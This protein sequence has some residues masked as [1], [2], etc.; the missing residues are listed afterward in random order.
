MRPRTHVRLPLVRTILALAG[1]L[2]AVPTLPAQDMEGQKIS[3]RASFDPA[4]ARPGDKVT[5]KLDVEIEDGWHLYG[6]MNE[7]ELSPPP[8]LKLDTTVLQRS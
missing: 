3:I 5:L 7:G 1:V 4:T 6:S 2:L 8:Q